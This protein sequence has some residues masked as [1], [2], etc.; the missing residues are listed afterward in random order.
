MGGLTAIQLLLSLKRH[1]LPLLASDDHLGVAMD[2][3]IADEKYSQQTWSG[4]LP[5]LRLTLIA[6]VMTLSAC[7]TGPGPSDAERFRAAPSVRLSKSFMVIETRTHRDKVKLLSDPAGK[8]HA[9]IAISQSRQIVDVV[10]GQDGV[11]ARHLIRDNVAPD[12][13]D[14]AFDRQGRM[15]VV[16]DLEHFVQNDSAW[17]VTDD[18]PWKRAGIQPYKAHFV[19]GWPDLLW[20]F[21]LSGEHVG[22]PGR[23][24]ILELGGYGGAMPIPLYGHAP[25]IVLAPVLSASVAEPPA[26]KAGGNERADWCPVE[27]TTTDSIVFTKAASDGQQTIYLLYV[28]VGY[29]PVIINFNNPPNSETIRF[30][31]K[32]IEPPASEPPASNP[33]QTIPQKTAGTPPCTLSGEPVT[34]LSSQLY[35][36][37][38]VAVDRDS[39]KALVLAANSGGAIDANDNWATTV[40][41]PLDHYIWPHI[42]PAGNGRFHVLIVQQQLGWW[43]NK[44]TISY[45]MRTPTAWSRTIRLG[46]TDS[47]TWNG[48]IYEAIDMVDAPGGRAFMAWPVAEGIKGQWIEPDMHVD[49][50]HPEQEPSNSTK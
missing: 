41:P 30:I 44:Y 26:M 37:L 8:V 32:R 36:E 13:I 49:D 7:A 21:S 5:I 39:G 19:P 12:N 9:V 15:H 34:H 6:I 28:T 10:I 16:S 50:S 14:A 33:G 3:D 29:S 45:L 23:F 46:S 40:P 47:A 27:P 22:T 20:V 35:S 42:A 38:A 31:R 2:P 4:L 17:E 24:A 43:S 18:T 1:A 25:K 11:E 48:S